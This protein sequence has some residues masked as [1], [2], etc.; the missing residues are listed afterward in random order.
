MGDGGQEQ[1]PRQGQ[2]H[3]GESHPPGEAEMVRGPADEKGGGRISDQVDDDDVKTAALL[4]L[5]ELLTRSKMQ[6]SGAL[7]APVRVDE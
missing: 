5:Q 2:G 3:Q 7:A 4:L 1:H 6:S